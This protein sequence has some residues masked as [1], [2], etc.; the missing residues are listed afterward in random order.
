MKLITLIATF[1]AVTAAV[2]VPAELQERQCIFNGSS[3]CGGRTFTCQPQTT[4][5]SP[6]VPGS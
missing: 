4:G 5:C 2:A 6:P 3:V 1:I